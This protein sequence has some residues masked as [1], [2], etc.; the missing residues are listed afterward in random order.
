MAD[1]ISN[2]NIS[3][4]DNRLNS[5]ATTAFTSTPPPPQPSRISSE[6]PEVVPEQPQPPRQT[7]P[8]EDFSNGVPVSTYGETDIKRNG[9][10]LSGGSRH[11][12]QV[13]I[14]ET[15]TRNYPFPPTPSPRVYDWEPIPTTPTPRKPELHEEPSHMGEDRRRGRGRKFGL[16]TTVVLVAVAFLLGGGIGG[17]VGGALVAQE[18]SKCVFTLPAFRSNNPSRTFKL[19]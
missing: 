17:G 16:V 3:E 5:M 19:T 4:E 18:K 7:L 8:R 14:R 1:L 12:K 13:D 2:S 11:Q 10:I 15:E 6:A 9:G